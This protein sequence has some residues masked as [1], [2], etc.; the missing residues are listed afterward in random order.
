MAVLSKAALLA[1]P[2]DG[3]SASTVGLTAEDYRREYRLHGRPI[4]WW[5][6]LHVGVGN[7]GPD[8]I[9]PE[10]NG[11]C[12]IEQ[13]T[14]LDGETEL[15]GLKVAVFWNTQK[16]VPHQQ[17][18]YVSV[19]STEISVLP[20]EIELARM[21]RLCP[22]DVSVRRNV[23]ITKVSGSHDLLPFK[24]V[25]EITSI[26]AN[27]VTLSAASYEVEAQGIHWL[28]AIPNAGTKLVVEYRDNPQFEVT[29]TDKG[30]M[31]KGADELYLPQRCTIQALQPDDEIMTY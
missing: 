27:G 23:Q 4:R 17:W 24:P 18:G 12:Y 15:A 31:Q 2:Y 14:L 6:A 30:L 16:G 13:E 5:K 21:D 7:T 10:Q 28:S 8:D 1:L 3:V 20:D 29:G 26:V 9:R 11:Y 19:N 22:A 25:A